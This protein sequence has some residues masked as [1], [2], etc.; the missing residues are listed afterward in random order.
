MDNEV[1]T[2]QSITALSAAITP[3]VAIGVTVWISTR[4]TRSQKR[5][6][7]ETELI[8][9]IREAC[10]AYVEL[11]L[12]L[13]RRARNLRSIEERQDFLD[14]DAYEK[15]RSAYQYIMMFST[16]PQILK[17]IDKLSELDD[18]RFGIVWR[19]I[20]EGSAPISEGSALW[21]EYQK[22]DAVF[23]AYLP[24]FYVEIRKRIEHHTGD[25]A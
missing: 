9:K 12:R 18:A 4:A 5:F 21:D 10:A 14:S 23:R 2:V 16:D 15:V 25:K 1:L 17:S 8:A 13:G 11:T 3:L 19:A 22:A 24:A 20:D 7:R 6:D